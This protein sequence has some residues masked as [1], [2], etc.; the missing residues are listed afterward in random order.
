M[1]V[2]LVEEFAWRGYVLGGARRALRSGPWAIVVSSVLFGLWHLP[3]SHDVLQVIVTALIGA[4]YATAMLK[5]RHCSTLAT[6]T[7]HGLHDFTLLLI[8]S[9]SA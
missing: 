4:T 8:A 7:A 6:G 2:A 9:L 5:A 3:G 1:L